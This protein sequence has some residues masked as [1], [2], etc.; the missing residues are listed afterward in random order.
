MKKLKEWFVPWLSTARE[1]DASI[2]DKAWANSDYGRLMLNENPISPSEKVVNAV[3]ES[4][5]KGNRYPDS[6]KA[7]RTKIG[8]MY[9]LGPDNVALNYNPEPRSEDTQ[10]ELDRIYKGFE[11]A[12]KERKERAA[13]A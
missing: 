8:K 6:M 3:T 11:D 7:L 10:K 5:T 2:L 4:V 13:A 9:E 12:V 1:Y